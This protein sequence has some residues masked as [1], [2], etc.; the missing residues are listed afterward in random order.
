LVDVI[1]E[2]LVSPGGGLGGGHIFGDRLVGAVGQRSVPETK[3]V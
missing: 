1:I 3:S 2:E